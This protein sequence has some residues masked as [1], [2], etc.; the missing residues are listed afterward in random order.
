MKKGKSLMQTH[1]KE[2]KVRPTTLEQIWGDTGERKYKTMEEPKY[3]EW[4]NSINKSDL[5][6]HAAQIGIV[7]IDNREL[8]TRKLIKE[9]RSHVAAFRMPAEGPTK[10]SHPVSR[11]VSKILAEGR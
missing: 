1:G 2:E 11:E 4:L 9:F 7:P 8:L 6:A 10:T 5:Q 3:V